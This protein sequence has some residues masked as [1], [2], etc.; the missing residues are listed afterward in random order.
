MELVKKLIALFLSFLILGSQVGF[1]VSTHF[2]RGEI[3]ESAISLVGSKVGCGMETMESSCLLPEKLEN[4]ISKKSCCDD[5]SQVYQLH[6]N[7]IK[8][9]AAIEVETSF[10]NLFFTTYLPFLE[11]KKHEDLYANLPTPPLIKKNTLVLL[12]SFLL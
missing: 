12:Q 5:E 8:K 2:C 1:A 7:F 10:L 11:A 9:Q 3:A 4:T 6:E